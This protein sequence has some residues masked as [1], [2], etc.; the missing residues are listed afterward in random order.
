MIRYDAGKCDIAVIGA[1]HAGIDANG[2]P[3]LYDLIG[4][5]ALYN[6]GTGSFTLR[7]RQ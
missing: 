6:L 7:G 3:C 4:K 2:V 5:T 1:G